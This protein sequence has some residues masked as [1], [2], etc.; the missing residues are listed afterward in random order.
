MIFFLVEEKYLK[1]YRFN[2][3]YSNNLES[4]KQSAKNKLRYHEVKEK[5]EQSDY[6]GEKIELLKYKVIQQTLQKEYDDKILAKKKSEKKRIE[7]IGKS[8]SE[9][10]SSKKKLMIS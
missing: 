5:L 3:D 10:V 4:E 8:S 9:V 1:I 2:Q 6:E 7:L